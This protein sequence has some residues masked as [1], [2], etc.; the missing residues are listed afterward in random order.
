MSC[1]TFQ[2][3]ILL[4]QKHHRLGLRTS[5]S[6]NVLP[7]PCQF[8]QSQNIKWLSTITSKNS[9]NY[10]AKKIKPLTIKENS[11]IMSKK[12]SLTAKTNHHDHQVLETAAELPTSL[13]S[14]TTTNIK[15][16]NNPHGI[17]PWRHSPHPLGRLIPDTTEY[18]EQGG[19]FGPR[20]PL[21]V[22]G[23]MA[24]IQ[25]NVLWFST[26]HL[27]GVSRPW[28]YLDWKSELE[29]GFMA[30]FTLS[31][32]AVL[33][34]V[35]QAPNSSPTK[36]EELNTNLQDEDEKISTDFEEMSINVDHTI[37][38]KSTL[39][40]DADDDRPKDNDK[41]TKEKDNLNLTK[42]KKNKEPTEDEEQ[43][44]SLQDIVESNLQSLYQSARATPNKKSSSSSSSTSPPLQINLQCYPKSAEIVSFLIVPFLDRDKVS[45]R[46]DL[47]NLYTDLNARLLLKGVESERPLTFLQLYDEIFEYC[48]E[49]IDKEYKDQIVPMTLVAQASIECDEIFWVKDTE[50]GTVVQGDADGQMRNVSHLV[51]FEMVVNYDLETGESEIGTWKIT[52]W[53]DLLD[54][55]IWYI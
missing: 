52:D 33:L 51:R 23:I 26:V 41:K 36:D 9:K 50:T 27:L 47:R 6:S 20:F 28:T 34:D 49:H 1:L 5:K 21:I 43:G 8:F 29:E 45:Q 12:D 10:D 18:Y 11:T 15:N 42:E 19:E 48:N 46:P 3:S 17:F 25:K 39:T 32:R 7:L 54:G 55:N 22:T 37:D 24:T 31:V 40:K 38:E 35:Y 14:S 53:D 16:S 30:A 4:L 2:R 44:P 13:N